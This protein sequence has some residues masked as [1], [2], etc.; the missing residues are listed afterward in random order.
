[1]THV[2]L[3]GG[4]VAVVRRANRTDIDGVRRMH[5]ACSS[6]TLRDRYLGSPPILSGAEWPEL[7]D[8]PGG[9][10]LVA[11]AG[12]GDGEVLGLAQVFGRRPVAEIAV[13]V[14]D[15]HQRRGLGTILARRAIDAAMALAYDDMVAYG[16]AGNA[17]ISRL[18]R[19]LE[20]RSQVRCV[21]SIVTVRA[22][23]GAAAT[24]MS[25]A[26]LAIVH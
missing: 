7:L 12:R 4:R 5:F 25:G 20:L 17:G 9:C 10:A 14:R 21:G 26:E 8:P 22:P 16:V 13:I 19:R 18:V 11:C 6:D 23:L 3:V 24:A 2:A 15:D 1:M